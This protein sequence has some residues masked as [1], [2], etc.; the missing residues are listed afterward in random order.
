MIIDL[1]ECDADRA[2]TSDVCIIGAG[3]AGLFLA[4][5]LTAR[6]LRVV[7]LE[8]GGRTQDDADHPL[9]HVKIV[10]QPY[11]GATRGRARCLGGTSTLWGGALIPFFESD[12]LARPHVGVEAWPVGF[13]ELEPY[14]SEI[15][16]IFGIDHSGYDG[17]SLDRVNDHYRTVR[18]DPDIVPRFAKWPTFKNR[19]VATLFQDTLSSSENLA[20]LLNAN[21]T[22]FA[23]NRETRRL[24]TITARSRTGQRVIVTSQQFVICSGAIEATR[25][26]LLLDR[27]TDGR[28]F[29]GCSALG[30]YFHDHISMPAGRVKPRD[31]DGL[32]RLA[33]FLFSGRTMRSLRFELSSP[34]QAADGVAS[35]FAHIGF[36]ATRVSGFAALRTIMQAVQKRQRVRGSDLLALGQDLPYVMRAGY[37]RAVYRQLLWPSP[38]NY[39]L[40]MVAEQLPRAENRIVLDGAT[41]MFDCQIAAIDWRVSS[42]DMGT[43]QAFAKR[44]DTFWTRQGL[45]MVADI[46]WILDLKTDGMIDPPSALG[47]IYHPGGTTRMGCDPT[48]SVVNADLTT[49]AV[50]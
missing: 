46:D 15:E 22:D 14:P 25:L 2:E 24:E 19:N 48:Q 43:I 7:V 40:H 33:G 30:R 16:D 29:E 27:Q 20:V 4:T 45:D 39:D 44:F 18:S 41:D 23:I 36:E 49:F 38:A 32:N 10:G 28:P 13:R 50:P 34:A 17:T 9:N 8:S 21:A 6:G 37:W 47:D 26:A 5:R 42:A 3:I 12:L 1:S 11:G 35:A 31:R